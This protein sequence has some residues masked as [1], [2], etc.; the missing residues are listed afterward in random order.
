[1]RLRGF[2]RASATG[3]LGSQP[4][5]TWGATLAVGLS[6]GLFRGELSASYFGPQR[7]SVRPDDA[8]Q[9][10]EFSLVV[11]ALRGCLAA[12]L[13]GVD[14]GACL[15]VELGVQAGEAFGVT[16]PERGNAPWLALPLAATLRWS[17]TRR[18]GLH[19]EGGAAIPLLRR[20]FAI[21]NLGAVFRPAPA[22]LR[23]SAGV[24]V[25]F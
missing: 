15:G 13:G 24:E 16:R 14:L 3:D 6:A 20:Q 25:Y 8:S 23:A 17:L 12:P 1:M 9:G 18:V 4:S 7:A 11:A 22:A 10:G 19:V 21:E 5:L 2:A